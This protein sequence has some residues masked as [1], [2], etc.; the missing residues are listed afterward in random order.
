MLPMAASIFF[1]EASEKSE[2]E[3]QHCHLITV[4]PIYLYIK[5][6][7][8]LPYHKTDMRT[9]QGHACKMSSKATRMLINP[10]QLIKEIG[11]FF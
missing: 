11:C 3:S 5:Q 2:F 6:R 4:C 8:F 9:K 7:S 1:K 10:Q